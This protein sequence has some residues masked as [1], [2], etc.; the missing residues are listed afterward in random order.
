MNETIE[1][2]LKHQDPAVRQL[3]QVLKVKNAN[4]QLAL[5]KIKESLIDL[6]LQVKSLVFDL[7]CTRQERDEL[8]AKEY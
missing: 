2:L 1:V 4:N 5:K 7:Q 8:R 3:A 6:R